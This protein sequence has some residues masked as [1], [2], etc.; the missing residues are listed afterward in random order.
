MELGWE[1]C[2]GWKIC[3]DN[4]EVESGWN[5]LTLSSHYCFGSMRNLGD[6]SSRDCTF[7]CRDCY[8]A[9]SRPHSCVRAIFVGHGT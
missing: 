1:N 6:F 9:L 7:E 4:C 8:G 2:V 5:G 3:V